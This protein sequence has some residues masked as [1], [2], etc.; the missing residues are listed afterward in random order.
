MSDDPYQQR[1]FFEAPTISKEILD[2]LQNKVNS[3]P[4]N[5]FKRSARYIYVTGDVANKLNSI[6]KNHGKNI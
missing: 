3:I 5:K 6:N 2:D 1:Q 4:D